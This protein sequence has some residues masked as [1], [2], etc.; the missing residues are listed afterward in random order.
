MPAYSPVEQSLRQK[1]TFLG[2]TVYQPFL[3]IIKLTIMGISRRLE[4]SGVGIWRAIRVT[5]NKKDHPP[6][7]GNILSSA[8][9]TRV[10]STYTALNT[11]RNTLAAKTFLS[12]QATKVKNAAQAKLQMINSHYIQVFNFMI[13]E[14]IFPKEYR[15]F[16]NIPVTSGAV[17]PQ[18]NGDDVKQ[19]AEDIITGEAAMIAA[20]G[21]ALLF[22]TVANVTAALT[23]YNTAATTQSNAKE[24]TDIAEE[25]LAALMPDAR[26]VMVKVW[27]EVETYFNEETIES[28]RVNAREW[29]VVYVSD[30]PVATITGTVVQVTG[31]VSTPLAGVLVLIEDTDE[32]TTT[33]ADGTFSIVTHGISDVTLQFTLAG[34]T[35]KEV[36]AKVVQGEV[37]VLGEVVMTV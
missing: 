15:S 24:E 16:F 30:A 19:L 17:P 37:I 6:S 26:K 25:A 12:T 5:K 11:A 22:P 2:K 36:N 4:N 23:A 13:D 7:Y 18:R 1:T 28:R 14:E 29:G 21:T 3:L 20:G 31:G 32:T 33:A 35:D 9:S 27:D 8:T 34:Y 10:D